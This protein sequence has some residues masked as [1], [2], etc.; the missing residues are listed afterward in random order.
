[1]SM[2]PLLAAALVAVTLGSPAAYAQ[3]RYEGMSC[4]E[5]WYARNE[6]YARRGYCFES[7]RAIRTFGPAC[8]PPYGRLSPGEQRIVEDIQ[9]WERAYRCP[10]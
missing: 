9:Y 5:L 7:E 4:R 1:M 3:S 8:F 10:R 2:R 6:I